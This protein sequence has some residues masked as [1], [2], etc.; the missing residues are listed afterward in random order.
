VARLAG[1]KPVA[2]L[3]QHDQET[4]LLWRAPVPAAAPSPNGS[5][6]TIILSPHP[7][8][9]PLSLGGFMLAAAGEALVVDVFSQTAACRFGQKQEDIPKI[10]SIRHAEESLMSRLTGAGLIELNQPE[11]LLRGHSLKELFVAPKGPAEDGVWQALAA[12]VVDLAR[13]HPQARWF[14]PLG[15]GNHIDHRVT[16]DAARQALREASV[17]DE[18]VAFYEDLGYAA[19]VEWRG[20]L[21]QL[22]PGRTLRPMLLPMKYHADWKWELVRLYWSQFLWP[23]ILDIKRY[24]YRIGNSIPAER[25]WA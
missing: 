4:L 5:V 13:Q 8:D 1:V 9:A 19:C 12:A 20:Q 16:R 18:R 24:A 11:A 22:V 15:V 14:L 21:S 6:G 2:L 23:D 25:T 7:D 17:P 10:Q 3:Q